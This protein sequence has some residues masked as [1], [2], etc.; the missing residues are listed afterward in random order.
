MVDKLPMNNAMKVDDLI[1][2]NGDW[3][4]KSFHTSHIVAIEH[5]KGSSRICERSLIMS[6]DVFLLYLSSVS[7]C[8]EGF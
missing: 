1:E 8:L 7:S 6:L 4:R 3:A 5:E 2:V